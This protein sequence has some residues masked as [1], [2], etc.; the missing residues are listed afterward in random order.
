MMI[1]DLF[2][3][4]RGCSREPFWLRGV[5]GC[6]VLE[7]IVDIPGFVS[8]LRKFYRGSINMVSFVE[9]YPDPIE[10]ILNGDVI[11]GLDDETCVYISTDHATKYS[12]YDERGNYDD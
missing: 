1:G 11:F 10:F 12:F 8:L 9:D 4:V 7:H 2:F 6:E 3:I 5:S